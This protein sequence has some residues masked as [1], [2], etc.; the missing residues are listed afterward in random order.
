[1]TQDRT[2]RLLERTLPGRE[3]G[4]ARLVSAHRD[5]AAQIVLHFGTTPPR[6]VLLDGVD[7]SS[8]IES[9]AGG[10]R[11]CVPAQGSGPCRV[12]VDGEAATLVPAGIETDLLSG[13]RVLLGVRH[14]ESAKVVA[15]WLRYHR[16]TQGAEAALVLDCGDPEG[17]RDF[18]ASVADAL[19]ADSDPSTVLL[20]TADAPLGRADLPPAWHPF[21]APAAPGRARMSPPPP[22]PFRAPL[23]ET[24]VFEALRRIFLD[25]ALAVLCLDVC[26]LALPSPEGTAFDRA[27]GL[28]D[29][30]LGLSGREVYPWR[31][32]QGRHAGF[33][34]HICTQFDD[35][36]QRRRW[37]VAPERAAGAVWRMT[38]L[39]GVPLH[40]GGSEFVRCIALRHPGIQVSAL[41]PKSSLVE[42][43]RLLV[44]ARDAFGGDPARAPKAAPRRPGGG[45]GHVTVVTCM[46]NEGPFVLEWLAYHRAI[47]VD[48]FL[49]YS[50][51]CTDGTD[52]LLDILEARGLV[53]HRDNPYRT[54][55][56]RPQHA[57]FL[58]AESEPLVTSADWLVA[59][60]VDE[61]INIHVGEGRLGDLFAATGDANMISMT[62]RLFGN[63][64]IAGY[65]DT[66]VTRQFI[67]CAPLNANKPHQ[68][69]GFKTLYRHEGLFR[70]IGVHRPKGLIPQLKDRIRWVNGS[71]APMPEAAYRN[72]W[73]ST[74]RT[75]G[76]DLVTL[77]HYAVRSAESFLVKRDR[78]RV[79][80]VDRDQG[81][82]YW[83]RMNNNA[84]TDLSIQRV[85][86]AMETELARLKADPEIA[87]AHDASVG[88][89][90]QRIA[91]LLVD[92]ENA[93][94]Y[95]DL[96]GDRM[97]RLSRL[98]PHFGAGVFWTGPQCVPE[99]IAKRDPAEPFFF[100]AP[101]VG[102][103]H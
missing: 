27:L 16:V 3:M 21:N 9:I 59:M 92:P 61:F 13:R 91:E 53:E 20:V 34:D 66:P 65:A 52:R 76:Y 46:K 64:D 11:L 57:A 90:R 68:S 103:G 85:L 89:H 14:A 32:R 100:T 96:V 94:F 93:A 1:M 4:A 99:E 22:D 78:G 62:W 71:G 79:N 60:D 83:F 31:L 2:P 36:A 56:Q 69:W 8:R 58:S 43:A 12:A 84:E 75:V 45:P 55:G 87:R 42:D 77:N 63:A 7:Q 25:R 6:T 67:R 5:G 44:L 51:D 95:D 28:E 19:E 73:R 23:G 41:V 88:H 48:R 38:R 29:G 40:E 30:Y 15:D 50:N 72:A 54:T 70:K 33:A 39:S 37:A 97:R 26:D 18:A 10:F 80:H 82:L 101:A 74:S 24:V 35:S 47:G 81:L 17:R 49:I 98:L 86:P 102:K